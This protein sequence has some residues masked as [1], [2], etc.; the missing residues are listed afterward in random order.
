MKVLVTGSNSQ[1]AKSIKKLLNSKKI[2]LFF[3][4]KEY[5]DVSNYISTLKIFNKI[6]PDILINCAAYTD[7][8]K[9]ETDKE[10]ANLVN[11]L[12]LGHLS[13]LCND[14][15]TLLIH[16]STDYVF[17]GKKK[18][19]YLED[20]TPNPISV[21]GQTKLNGEKKI[22]KLSK[23]FLIFRV[24]WLFSIYQNNFANFV[25]N[26]LHKNEDIYA[27]SDLES[28]PT[29]AMEMALF[30]KYFIENYNKDNYSDIYHFNSGGSEISWY[31]FAM[32][33]FQFYSKYYK[34]NSNIIKLSSYK[35]FG[36]N[37]RP[38]FSAMSNA[39]LLKNFEYKII[40]LESSIN[41]LFDNS[42]LNKKNVN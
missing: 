17:D 10:N 2:K 18:T 3:Y 40:D 8:K 30:L 26:K 19:K 14:Y 15:D 20:D 1:L 6:H 32:K 4:S 29:D 28:I 35:F 21:Y 24:S 34:S 12:S 7:V 25:I 22:L 39:K 37:I 38:S 41:K 42:L 13:T 33:I 11:N 23:N 31:D 27:I 9:A 36:N 16:F 5:L